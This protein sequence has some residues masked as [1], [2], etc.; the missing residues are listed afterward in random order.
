MSHFL[1][2]QDYE[3][4]AKGCIFAEIFEYVNTHKIH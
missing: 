1:L 4:K 3:I 2:K